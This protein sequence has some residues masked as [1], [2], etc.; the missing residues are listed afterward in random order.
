MRQ[1]VQLDPR[2]GQRRHLGWCG[3]LLL[4]LVSLLA[5]IGRVHAQ[6]AGCIEDSS[7]PAALGTITFSPPATI[8]LT[9]MP[10]A[11]TVLWSSGAVAATPTPVYDCYGN[12][13]RGVSNSMGA[14]PSS[15]TYYATG[16]AGLSYQLVR[17]GT[18]LLPWPT[19]TYATPG[20]GSCTWSN[21]GGGHWNCTGGSTVQFSVTTQ[22]NLVV[23]G[24]IASGSVLNAG[25]LGYWQFQGLGSNGATPPVQ[26]IAFA[27]GNSTTITLP[28]CTV[29]TSSISVTLPNISTSALGS[30]GATAGATPFSIGLN[31]PSAAAGAPLYVELN[32]NGTASGI[33]GVLTPTAGT[34]SGVGVQVLYSNTPVTFGTPTQVGTTATGTM[35]IPYT[36]QYYQTQ[37]AAVTP[38]TL[39]ASATFMI[40]YE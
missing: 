5:P 10:A 30:L 16:V 37:A 6:T 25:T 20:G 23:T 14:T 18:A 9:S 24:P 32:Y 13:P 38:G 28:T 27:L 15:G 40:M 34:S 3:L 29:T 17:G 19:D 2:M 7:S 26:I 4:L 33:Q 8:T 36:A 21:S 31:C 22:L 39:T 1:A 12:V 11:G 35:S